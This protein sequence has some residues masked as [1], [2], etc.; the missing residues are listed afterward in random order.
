MF[1]GF[2]CLIASAGVYYAFDKSDSVGKA[3]VVLL[4]LGSI[5]TW[6]IMIEKGIGL[7]RAKKASEDFS[8]RFRDK[9]Q[10]LGLLRDAEK[11]ISPVARVYEA[12]A[13]RLLNS[14]GVPENA[15]AVQTPPQKL[16][17]AEIE[18]VRTVMEREVSDQILNLEDKIGLLATAVSVSPFFGLFGTVWGVM[19]AFC[20]IAS[21]G[22]AD[23]SALAP[24]VSG[25]LLTTVVGLLVAIPSLIGYNLLTNTIRKV[26]IYMDNFVEEVMARIKLEQLDVD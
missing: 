4:F 9:N 21:Q 18:A 22:R 5:L 11:S 23:I 16:T 8:A 2:N 13:E 14:Y 12:G 6:T 26:T 10:L 20:S 24:G 1:T 3:V 15:G 17:T 7:Y 19:M 25:A